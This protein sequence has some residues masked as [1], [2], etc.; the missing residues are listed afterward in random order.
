MVAVGVVDSD[1][2][3]NIATVTTATYSVV[4]NSKRK[5]DLPK[6]RSKDYKYKPLGEARH[7]S[8][9]LSIKTLVIFCMKCLTV[10][11]VYYSSRETDWLF[12]LR[13]VDY[14]VRLKEFLVVPSVKTFEL[15]R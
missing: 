2:R 4:K 5:L 11:G 13:L 1:S 8:I 14:R 12:V 10:N 6:G 15:C 3:E 9:F 7:A